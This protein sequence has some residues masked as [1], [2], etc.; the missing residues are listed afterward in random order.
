MPHTPNQQ[1]C[2]DF[3][4]EMAKS[5]SE[6]D[7]LLQEYDEAIGSL[8][9][10]FMLDFEPA[11]ADLIASLRDG[12]G[13]NE[14]ESAFLLQ[15]MLRLSIQFEVEGED[16]YIYIDYVEGYEREQVYAGDFESPEEALCHAIWYG[17]ERWL[18]H[19]LLALAHSFNGA[20]NWDG[21]KVWREA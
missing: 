17:A 5:F 18:E 15:A 3:M 21:N 7:E 9:V 6:D 16:E 19:K 14:W 13:R 11:G 20:L 2:L 10:I 4:Q 8:K 1:A 12:A